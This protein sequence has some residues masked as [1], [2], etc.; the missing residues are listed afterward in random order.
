V[1]QGI[2][3]SKIKAKVMAAEFAL[4]HFGMIS[5][6]SEHVPPI[7]PDCTEDYTSDVSETPQFYNFDKKFLLDDENFVPW[8]L[9]EKVDLDVPVISENVASIPADEASV[10]ADNLDSNPAVDM[11]DEDFR[12][13]L[14]GKTPLTI[15]GE[16]Q[17]GAFYTLMDETGDQLH[18]MF[19]MSVTINDETFYGAGTS[20]KLAKARAARNAL[21]KMYNIHFSVTE[22]K[23]AIALACD[24]VLVSMQ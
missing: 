22:S 10:S 19:A 7:T 18:P 2:G 3:Q 13:R 5:D 6:L 14:L 17:L 8:L 23:L 9:P 11:D 24:S 1:F 20:K 21:Q 12:S 15:V 4:M 16:L